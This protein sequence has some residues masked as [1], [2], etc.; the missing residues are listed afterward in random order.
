LLSGE[1]NAE[2]EEKEKR[3]MLGRIQGCPWKKSI[4]ERLMSEEKIDLEKKN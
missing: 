1:L 2:S 4:L 3:T